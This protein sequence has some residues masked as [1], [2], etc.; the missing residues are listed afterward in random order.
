[1]NRVDFKSEEEKQWLSLDV[2]THHVKANFEDLKVLGKG[3]FKALIK[4]RLAIREEVR[5][6]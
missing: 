5:H 6:D 1:M 2:T 3:E 4:W